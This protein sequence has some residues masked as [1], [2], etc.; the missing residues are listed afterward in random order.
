M[1]QLAS[2]EEHRWPEAAKVANRDFYV[3]DVMTGSDE[4][5][6]AI[7]LQKDLVDLMHSGGFELRKWASNSVDLLE[8][9]PESQ[10]EIKLPL[11]FELDEGIKTLGVRWSPATD[12]FSFTVNISSGKEIYTK[13]SFLSEVSRLFDPLGWTA[14]CMILPKIIFQNLW[15]KH[16][17]WDEVLQSSVL[18]EWT[19]FREN[20]AAIEQIRIPRWIQIH[21]SNR[22]CEL[23]GF[24]D[25]SMA[26]YATDVYVRVQDA[27][28]GFLVNLLSAKTRVAPVKEISLP[29]LELCG[30]TSSRC[31]GM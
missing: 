10:R 6:D 2:D 14:P 16:V 26:A 11:D 4:L 3:D 5:E 8:R 24:C 17:E 19:T 22:S 20:L 31:A 13:R 9:I 25:A 21:N 23:H 27:S 18:A 1:Q 12:T 15:K 28:G 29:K 7:K 30:A